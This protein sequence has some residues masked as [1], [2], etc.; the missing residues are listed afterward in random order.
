MPQRPGLLAGA[1]CLSLRLSASRS[2]P[3]PPH[4]HMQAFNKSKLRWKYIATHFDKHKKECRSKYAQLSGKPAP[5]EED[6]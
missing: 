6:D 1:E 3:S 5:V 2:A 4:A